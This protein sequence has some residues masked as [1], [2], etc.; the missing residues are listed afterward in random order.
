MDPYQ[1]DQQGFRVNKLDIDPTKL[2]F[3]N[4]TSGGLSFSTSFKSKSADGKESKQKDIPIDPFMT[5]DEQQRQLQYAKSNPAE[6]T[7]FNIPWTLNVSY[8]FI[9]SKPAYLTDIKQTLSF[10][11][12]F[13][14]TDNWKVGMNS[15][16]D[17]K[18]KKFSQS[19]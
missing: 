7:D 3:G 8:N 10:N 15:G 11:G 1:T 4:I 6:F 17:L 12:D 2:K 13:N 9:Y 18:Q 5:P 19:I 14:I 16:F